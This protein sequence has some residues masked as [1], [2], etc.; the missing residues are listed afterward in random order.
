MVISHLSWRDKTKVKQRSRA[1]VRRLVP[2][3]FVLTEN[4]SDLWMWMFLNVACDGLMACSLS[5]VC[6][7]QNILCSSL[8]MNFWISRRLFFYT[9]GHFSPTPVKCFCYFLP[10]FAGW[11]RSHRKTQG[12]HVRP[13]C[14]E[15]MANLLQQKEGK[16][17]FH[18]ASR[19]TQHLSPNAFCRLTALAYI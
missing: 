9:Y 10:I 4:K 17:T 1:L 3:V 11:T 8:I 19:Q 14:R 5:F 16:K 7:L 2:Y 6:V 18:C 13:A 15:E 12:G